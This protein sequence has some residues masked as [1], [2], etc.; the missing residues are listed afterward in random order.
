V[1]WGN[2]SPI[3]NPGATNPSVTS[4]KAIAVGELHSLILQ[5]NGMV[6]QYGTWAS[7]E[8]AVVPTG[9]N[10][11]AAIS[12]SPNYSLALKSNGTVVIWNDSFAGAVANLPPGLANIKAIGTGYSHALVLR[13]NGTVVAWGD[14]DS[15]QTNLLPG[16]SNVIAISAGE[17][18]S[19]ALKAD[20]NLVAWG[21]DG[22]GE[23]QLPSGLTNVTD[24]CAGSQISLALVTNSPIVI[25]KQPKGRTAF[26]GTRF[27]LGC[28]ASGA[29]PIGYQWQHNNQDVLGATNSMLSLTNTSRPD[30]GEYR[31]IITNTLGSVTS[32][33]AGIT[34]G[35]VIGWGRN[36][37]EGTEMPPGLTTPVSIAAYTSAI[38][39]NAD[40]SV[41]TW[42]RTPGPGP[43]QLTNVV[44]VVTGFAHLLALH[45][46]GK[47]EAW[48]D[49]T[50]GQTAFPAE[51]TNV[52][53]IAG[54][55]QHSVA[56]KED[57]TLVACGS[58][59]GTN[60]PAGLS[61]VTAIACGS[62]STYS[63]ALK[64]DG[65]VR[66]WGQSGISASSSLSNVCA[67]AGGWLFV[68]ALRGDGKISSW[69]L[70]GG[71]SPPVG[72]S[73]VVAISTGDKNVLAL[74]SD[75][76]VI[77]W[78]DTNF[79]QTAIPA[80]VS[81]VTQV[82]SGA[83]FHLAIVGDGRPAFPTRISKRSVR[84]GGTLEL[85]AF[86][87][88]SVPM[89]YQWFFNG[90]PLENQTNTTLRIPNAPAIIAGDY[91]VVVSNAVGVVTSAVMTVTVTRDPVR[92][93]TSADGLSV[94]NE[95]AHLRLTGLAGAGS[96]VLYASTNLVD[97]EPIYTNPPVVGVLDVTDFAVTNNPARYYRAVEGP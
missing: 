86:A 53:A 58:S 45:A 28:T 74:R 80:G 62:P 32:L 50:Y 4:V 36:V 94:T 20:G 23:S 41:A 91:R 46:N 67:L 89:T 5:S 42:G 48:G 49:N 75:G 40:G 68:N 25:S 33:V 6:S 90:Q 83:G 43:Q 51:W 95:S 8:F 19:L 60:V 85:P 12:T 34:L 84:A 7:G 10:G 37:Y 44:Q 66:G 72:L 77:A 16:L 64:A 18:H 2:G 57:G 27:R 17:S 92:F 59:A 76:T 47:A 65:T 96:V 71:S 13:S 70:Y 31:V 61:N 78:G 21:S 1:G 63:L 35:P 52:I 39:L 93:D 82:A 3:L 38:A 11:V 30:V 69:G 14:N 22:F 15:G 55:S 79:N 97:W 81:N 88:S 73:N 9:L 29:L 54:G 26:P 87:A 24:I 56:L